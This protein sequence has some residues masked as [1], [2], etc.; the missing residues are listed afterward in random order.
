MRSSAPLPVCP[1]AHAP[2]WSGGNSKLNTH[3]SKMMARIDAHD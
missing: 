2:G 1:S 3:N